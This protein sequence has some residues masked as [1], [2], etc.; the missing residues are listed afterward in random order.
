MSGGGDVTSDEGEAESLLLRISIPTI[1]LFVGEGVVD[2]VDG[3]DATVLVEG[4][5]LVWNWVGALV[6]V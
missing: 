3:V 2:G 4:F 1:S 5:T 6:G